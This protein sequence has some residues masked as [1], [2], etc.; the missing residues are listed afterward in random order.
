MWIHSYANTHFTFLDQ[1]LSGIG[2]VELFNNFENRDIENP[3]RKKRSIHKNFIYSDSKD[4][5]EKIDF[6]KSYSKGYIK[7]CFVDIEEY[8][9]EDKSSKEQ[10]FRANETVSKLEYYIQK[11][12]E[13]HPI[14]ATYHFFIDDLVELKND[15]KSKYSYAISSPRNNGEPFITK[16]V[17][18]GGVTSLADLFRRLLYDKRLSKGRT[19]IDVDQEAIVIQMIL[20]R[21]SDA[22][23]P[24][25]ADSLR[26]GISSNKPAK[27]NKV[28]LDEPPLTSE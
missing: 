12:S 25:D 2:I 17:W 15:V 13:Y 3:D 5:N 10:E 20:E 28:N 1:L 7:R 4:E 14:Y 22:G 8:I 6:L 23:K 21:F 27:R 16:I 19:F 26:R 11:L 24:F 9:N 18:N